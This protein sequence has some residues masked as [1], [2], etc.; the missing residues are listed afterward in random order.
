M[1]LTFNL[2]AFLPSVSITDLMPFRSAPID[3]WFH[4]AA[5]WDRNANEAGF[6]RDGQLVSYQG[7]VNGSYLRGN[8]HA[9][10]DIGLKR[11]DGKTF[12]GHLRDLMIIGEALT[13][14]DLNSILTGESE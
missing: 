12:K 5:Y 9:V 13:A 1:K 11:D 4:M 14:E 7:L 6:F 2:C 3:K 10:Y 8:D